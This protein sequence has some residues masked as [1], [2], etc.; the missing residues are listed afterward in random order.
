MALKKFARYSDEVWIYGAKIKAAIK[1]ADL[2][3]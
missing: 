1:V 2:K 3:D